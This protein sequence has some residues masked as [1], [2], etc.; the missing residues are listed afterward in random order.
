MTTSIKDL[1]ATNAQN[2]KV[3]NKAVKKQKSINSQLEK[4]YM[5]YHKKLIACGFYSGMKHEKGYYRGTALDSEF[6]IGEYGLPY[7]YCGEGDFKCIHFKA[8]SDGTLRLNYRTTF[9][10]SRNYTICTIPLDLFEPGN[11][12]NLQEY[13]N[14]LIKENNSTLEAYYEQEKQRKRRE[15]EAQ[16]AKLK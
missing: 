16:L 12:E 15:L 14:N 9:D 11:E 4:E 3:L 8:L 1:L 5:K 13:I 10:G 2:D 7:Q 6:R